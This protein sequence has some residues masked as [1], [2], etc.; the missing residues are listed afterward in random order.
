MNFI[1]IDILK[2]LEEQVEALKKIGEE[3]HELNKEL[4]KEVYN[5]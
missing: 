5:D 2:T 4:E 3:L 1:M